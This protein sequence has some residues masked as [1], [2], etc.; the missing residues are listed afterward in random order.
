MSLSL[1][2]QS[3][4]NAAKANGQVLVEELVEQ[5]NVT[6][7][8]IRKDL[9]GLCDADLLV[10]VHGGAV[11]ESGVSNV[12]Y[13]QRR[14][15]ASAEKQ[16]L[17]KLC[18]EQIPNKS[19][20]FINIGTTTE[21]VAEAL[22]NHKDLMVVTNN[23]NVA[24]ILI[25]NPTFEVI[26]AGGVLRHADRAIIGEAT[27]D[28]VKQFRLDFAVI[29]ISALDVDGTLLDYDYRE[30]RVAQAILDSARHCFLVTDT[31]KLERNAPVK[32]GH[33]SQL[34]ALFI[35]ALDSPAL[36]EVCEQ[37]EV[38]IVTLSDRTH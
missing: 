27:V 24:N 30:V 28:F 1:R 19:S 25:Q 14:T 37:H 23:L 26:V 21:A 31:T 11:L 33:V 16:K 15:I 12:G 10:R 32:V 7:Q 36:A 6:P 9:T 34:K 22:L 35:D 29:G 38:D 3:I 8:T 17:A 4:L 2:Q 5:F 20:L 13:E 18:A